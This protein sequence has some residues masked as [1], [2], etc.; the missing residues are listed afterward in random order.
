MCPDYVEWQAGISGRCITTLC[1]GGHHT[2]QLRLQRPLL[3]I[4]FTPPAADNVVYLLSVSHHLLQT[5]LSTCYRFHTTCCR[6]R[7]LLAIG[8]TPPAADNVVYLLSVSH[9]LL[10]TTSST[11]YRFHTTCCRQRCLLAIGF[12]LPAADNVVYLLS[13]SHHLLQATLSTCYR[14]HTTCCRQ[15]RLLAIGC[16]PPA[17]DNVFITF[18]SPATTCHSPSLTYTSGDD[19]SSV[20]CSSC[21]GCCPCRR[22]CLAPPVFGIRPTKWSLLLYMYG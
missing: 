2:T 22:Y 10:Q 5:T 6:Q 12:T 3:A 11:C 21:E 15:R 9:H 8:C 4:G 14:F 20:H 7:H 17:A 18:R 13:V 1:W 19:C 16:T